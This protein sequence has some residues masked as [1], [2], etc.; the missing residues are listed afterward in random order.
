MSETDV[1]A[2]LKKV[3]I[4]KDDFKEYVESKNDLVLWEDYED[5]LLK[6]GDE[7]GI[8]LLMKVKGAER[9]H[10]RK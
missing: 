10:R 1:K 5:D 9:I 7:S 3:S 2:L 4:N 8:S 6:K